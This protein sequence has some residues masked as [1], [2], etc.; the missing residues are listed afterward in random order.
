M[1]KFGSQFFLVSFLLLIGTFIFAQNKIMQ[2]YK[3]G[4]I[5]NAIEVARIDS[6]NFI[7]II[8][9]EQGVLIDGIRWATRNVDTPGTFAAIPEFYGMFYQWNR[10]TAWAA[11]GDVSGWDTS[12][13]SGT[14][15]EKDND[16]CPAGWRVPTQGELLSLV[17]SGSTWTI[18]SG[19]NGILFGTAPNQIFLPAAGHL[20]SFAGSEVRYWSSTQYDSYLVYYLY[21]TS[22]SVNFRT[23]GQSVRCVSDEYL[24]V[25]SV[26]L[27]KNSTSLTIGKTEQLTATVLQD[28]ATNKNVTW[29]SD[30]PIVAEVSQS[31]LITA[32]EVGTATITVTSEDGNKTATCAVEVRA[33]KTED[34]GVVIDGVRWATC[35]VD[36][37][38]T[39]AD[40]PELPGM[41]YQWNRKT[42][43]AAT[44]S[45][46]EWNSSM[47]SGTSWEKDNDPCPAGW[48]VPTQGELQSLVYSD[49]TWITISGV[50]GRLF[51]TA[52]NQI[53]LPAAGY[54][55]DSSGQPYSAGS[56]GSYWSSTPFLEDTSAYYLSLYSGNSRMNFYLRKRGLCIRCVAE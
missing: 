43:W 5:T 41:F 35:N 25:T 52:P 32:K 33:A 37:P 2:I 28:N 15:W 30:N 36:A 22:V 29:S 3:D 50:K 13:P 40:T 44:G 26:S 38:G 11:N 12:T 56:F 39:F 9:T 54:L 18:K 4:N 31:G 48:R 49:S 17:N 34:E 55:D 45:V 51:G 21:G 42:A 10:K 7:D 53:F 1:K 6:I 46:S 27:D 24:P 16:P 20:F 47:P 19:V 23:Y 8:D 14:S